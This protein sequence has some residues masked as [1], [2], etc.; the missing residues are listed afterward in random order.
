[1]SLRAV[2]T[3]GPDLPRRNPPPKLSANAPIIARKCHNGE[4]NGGLFIR[5]SGDRVEAASPQGEDVAGST[6]HHDKGK[7]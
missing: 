1:M 7:T 4:R 2:K 6:G 5:E 3:L